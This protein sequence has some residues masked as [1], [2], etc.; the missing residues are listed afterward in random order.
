[1]DFPSWHGGNSREAVSDVAA[2]VYILSVYMYAFIAFMHAS[3]AKPM[4]DEVF[5]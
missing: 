2:C 1:M 3:K 4:D 5:T